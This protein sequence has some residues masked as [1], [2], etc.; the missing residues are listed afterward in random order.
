MYFFVI[1]Y[2][3]LVI[4]FNLLP[5]GKYFKLVYYSWFFQE[6]SSTTSAGTVNPDWSGFQVPLVKT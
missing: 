2:V 3:T 6:Q 1:E 4:V 5:Y